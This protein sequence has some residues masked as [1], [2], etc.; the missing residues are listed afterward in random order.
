M[1][2]GTPVTLTAKPSKENS[3]VEWTGACSGSLPTCTVPIAADEEVG[4]VFSGTTRAFSP[5]EAL[6][7]SKGEGTGYGTVKG[8]SGLGCEAECTQTTVLYQ[9]PLGLKPGKTVTLKQ[10]PAFGSVFLGW[11]EGDCDS[12]DLEGNCV[13]T[14]ESSREV[15]AEYA[16]LPNKV[17]TLNKA[18][19]SGNGTVLSKPKGIKCAAACTQAVAQMPE[20]SSVE[21]TA[22]PGKETTFVEW[23][24]PGGDCNGSTSA[25]CTVGMDK[26]E[27]LEAVFSNPSKALSSEAEL[28]LNKAGSG[29]GTVKASGLGCEVL[30]SSTSVVY[31]GPYE[32]P[33]GA[34]PG[35]AVV[36]KATSA[37]GSGP[38]QWGAGDCDEEPV[39]EG[40]VE[41]LVVMEATREVTASF[42][43]LE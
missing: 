5:A 30:C 16:A 1:Y 19:S 11:G 42:D 35:K 23:V 18:Y 17:L 10:A 15:S 37:P 4:A 39:V 22:K 9:G 38:V 33:Y 3:F 34:K 43:E 28:T 7:V 13:V 8:T 6:S 2:V 12:I 36:L 26:D 24:N 27:T 29:F 21:L 41:C 14:M 31:Q 20:G 32:G 25:T 40:S